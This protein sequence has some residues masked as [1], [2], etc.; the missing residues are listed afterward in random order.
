MIS[1][2]DGHTLFTRAQIDGLP[3]LNNCLS[4][5]GRIVSIVDCYD[6][7]TTARVYRE[8]NL[9]P[10]ESLKYLWENMDTPSEPRLFDR[11]LVKMFIEIMGLYPPGTLVQLSTGELGVVCAAP[12]LGTDPRRPKVRLVAG[13]QAGA[14]L[15]LDERVDD[16]YRYSVTQ[17]LNPANKGQV[18]AIDLAAFQLAD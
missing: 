4:L 13:E 9:T 12:A 15:D 7:L 18:P 16:E 1:T 2:T 8:Q 14:V 5:F 3:S 17:V 10:Y 6:A 11:A